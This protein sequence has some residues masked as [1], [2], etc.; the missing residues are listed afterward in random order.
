M[1]VQ[2]YSLRSDPLVRPPEDDPRATVPSTR[3]THTHHQ[4]NRISPRSTALEYQERE[5]CASMHDISPRIDRAESPPT[6]ASCSL[7]EPHLSPCTSFHTP[8]TF[9]YPTPCRPSPCE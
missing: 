7:Y 5:P 6:F 4:I 2:C 8:S 3:N 9:R 1:P